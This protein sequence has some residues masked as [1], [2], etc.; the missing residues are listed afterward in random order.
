MTG[1]KL[2]RQR[3]VSAHF[4]VTVCEVDRVRMLRGDAMDDYDS[5]LAE[6]GWIVGTV[7]IVHTGD[8]VRRG[9]NDMQYVVA[10]VTE[11]KQAVVGG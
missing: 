4:N 5:V 11:T 10:R 7:E 1:V 9:I 6:P 2:T 3:L 8:P